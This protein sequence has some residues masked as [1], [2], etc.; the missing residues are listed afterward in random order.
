MNPYVLGLFVLLNAVSAVSVFLGYRGIKH[1]KDQ[2]TAASSALDP[3]VDQLIQLARQIISS[4]NLVHECT[5][6]LG[7]NQTNAIVP[8]LDTLS[9]DIKTV[10]S[11]IQSD[12]AALKK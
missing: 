3:K 8:R 11:S 2:S 9:G 4:V 10:P 12:I 7:Q 6:I 5:L 1:L